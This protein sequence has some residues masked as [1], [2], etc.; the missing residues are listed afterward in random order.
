MDLIAST[1][2]ADC[3]QRLMNVAD[4]VH[5]KL[6]SFDSLIVRSVSIGKHSLENLNPVHHAIVVIL[7][8]QQMTRIRTIAVRASE[9]SA[10]LIGISTKC[11]PAVSG[12]SDLIPSAQFATAARSSS[13][14]SAR[15]CERTEAVRC[16]RATSAMIRC[17]SGPQANDRAV[18]INRHRS[19][20]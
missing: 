18:K 13:P 1:C 12:R 8:A 7:F 10:A 2:L 6:Q 17:P 19:A 20:K 3:V 15:T 16:D 14:S 5:Q 11:Q 4:E 9:K